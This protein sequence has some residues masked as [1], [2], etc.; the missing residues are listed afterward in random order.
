MS[1]HGSVAP[2]SSRQDAGSPAAKDGGATISDVNTLRWQTAIAH[3]GAILW[4]L[5]SASVAWRSAAVL[6]KFLHSLG[7]TVGPPTTIFLATSR[8]W[9]VVPIVSAIFSVMSVRRI[10]THPKLAV[11]VLAA[12]IAVAFILNVWWREAW[13]G[14]LFALMGSVG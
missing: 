7:A 8:F 3:G 6:E 4:Q 9:I 14:P 10:A 13:F 5:Y 2:A 11:I 12:E 1:R